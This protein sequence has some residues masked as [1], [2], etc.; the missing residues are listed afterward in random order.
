MTKNDMVDFDALVNDIIEKGQKV[1]FW[2]GD[3]LGRGYYFDEVINDNHYLDAGP[4][5]ALDP[6]NRDRG[7]V[8]A[9]NGSQP[10]TS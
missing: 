5:Y 6:A 8:W 3:Q 2:M 1:W 10:T 7:A 4:S 9:T